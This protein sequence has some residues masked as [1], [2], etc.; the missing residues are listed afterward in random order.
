MIALVELEEGADM[1][2]VVDAARHMI[3]VEPNIEHGEVGIGLQL[4]KDYTPHASFSLLLDFADEAAW[5][6]YVE[7][8]EHKAL[9]ELGM[10]QARRVTA[11]QYIVGEG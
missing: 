2:G 5:R 7:G 1:A 10:A 3:E 11:T 9:D 4:M 6:R 8:E